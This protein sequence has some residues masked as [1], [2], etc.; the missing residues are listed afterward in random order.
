MNRI[1]PRAIG[2]AA[3][4][5]GVLLASYGWLKSVQTYDELKY[6]AVA[7]AGDS[8]AG[9]EF[10]ARMVR[11]APD[12]IHHYGLYVILGIAVIVSGDLVARKW[13]GRPA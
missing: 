3:R 13:G 7:L 12:S 8:P 6:Y 2:A 10:A 9:P 4:I 1:W 5:A 11:E